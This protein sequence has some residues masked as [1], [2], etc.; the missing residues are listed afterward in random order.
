MAFR[1]SLLITLWAAAILAGCNCGGPP[2]ETNADCAGDQ[3]CLQTAEVC[4]V[5]CSTDAE[6]AAEEKCSTAGGCVA[7]SQCGGDGDCAVGTVCQPGGGCGAPCQTAGCPAGDVC[8]SNGHCHVPD[9]APPA[10]G[11]QLFESKRVESNMLIVLD[12]SGSMRERADASGKSKW[13]AAKEAIRSVTAKHDQQIRFGLEI[14]SIATKQCAVQGVVVPVGASTAAAISSAL[15]QE[16]DGDRT[17]IGAAL[18]TAATVAE[19]KDPARANYVM[20]VTDGK[21]NCGGKPVDET[22]KL[23]QAGVKTFVVGFGAQVDGQM[24]S[25]MAVEGGTARAGGTKYYQANDA[26]S[27][28]SAF[29]AIA[30]GALGCDYQLEKAPPDPN[31]LFVYVNGQLTP[32]DPSKKSGW[33]YAGSPTRISLYGAACDAMTKASGG[34]VNIVYGCPDDTLVEGPGSNGPGGGSDG[35]FEEGPG[36]GGPGGPGSGSD[37]GDPEIL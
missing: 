7:K 21:E 32:R 2:C 13:D 15:P 17:P 6:C 27:L 10:C 18:S 4:A 24:L 16:A 1:A 28:S 9:K 12:H 14:F 26:A 11:G 31:K 8:A 33:D 34:K 36:S 30:Q 23:F 5:K 37:G 22:K 29:D 20:L 19:L 25:N 35:G 3:V